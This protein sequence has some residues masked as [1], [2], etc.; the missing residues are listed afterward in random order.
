MNEKKYLIFIDILGF[1]PLAEKIASASKIVSAEE[2]RVK[3]IN[4]IKEKVR[5][6]EEK[7]RII[8]KKY[9]ES[10]DWIL[11]T[12]TLDNAFRSIS[13][14]LDHNTGYKGYEKIP[15]EIA[16][17]TGEYDKWAKFDGADFIVEKDTIKFLKTNIVGHYHKR[18]P[19]P[20]DTFIVL[21]ES[22]YNELEPLD[23]KTCTGIEYED[24]KKKIHI[25]FFTA[26]VDKVQQ[27]DKVFKFLEKIDYMGKK[28]GRIDEVYVP[29]LEYEDIAETLKE[30]RFVFI[31]GTQEYGKT[32][33]AVR[34]M[35]KYYNKGYEPKWIKGGELTERVQGRIR[36]ENIS[37]ELKPRRIIYFED[38]FGK[39][40]YEERKGLERE[41]GIIIDYVAQVED[42]YIVVT[43]RE[44]VFKEFKK[45]KLSAKDLKDFEE[46]LNI[47]TP[48]YDYDKRKEILLKW[49]EDENCK[50]LSSKNLN[51]L[52]L[53]SIKDE[54]ILPTPLSIKGFAVATTD[55]EKEDALK[56]KINEKSKETAKAFAEEIKNMTPDKILFLSFLFIS[57]RFE[58]DFVRRTYQELAGGLNLKD[59]WEFDRVL[60]WFEDDKVNISEGHIEFSH[61]SYSEALKLLLIE[62]EILQR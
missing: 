56:E 18:Y 42:V 32:Y 58:V 38:P 51:K 54:R 49:A 60:N 46:K 45:G 21:T 11:V 1:G 57:S 27:R 52:V 10:D 59:A 12:D 33:T 16:I 20:K 29:P 6:T 40:K 8:G 34:L 25:K 14:I 47:K 44:E 28:Y 15:L 13:E 48:S 53:S 31:T 2:V 4:V 36:L 24:K 39:T 41:I 35:W 17:G 22:A 5:I 61:P 55:I 19:S 30:K 9:G 50:W 62:D 23:K 7:G 26:N 3:F 43:S 37:A